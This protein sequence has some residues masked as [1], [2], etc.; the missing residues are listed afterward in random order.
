MFQLYWLA[1]TELEEQKLLMKE[2]LK[3]AR[4][5]IGE[6]LFMHK[7]S[8]MTQ[9][10]MSNSTISVDSTDGFPSRQLSNR[11]NSVPRSSMSPPIATVVINGL[12]KMGTAYVVHWGDGDRRN[13]QGS[14]KAPLYQF[15]AEFLALNVALCTVSA[16]NI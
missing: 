8:R 10:S 13:K 3:H 6:Y 12:N 1:E 7:K 15:K 16:I 14:V 5:K 11:S 2:A 4:D 9:L